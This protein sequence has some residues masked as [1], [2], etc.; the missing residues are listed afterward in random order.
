M[1]F[2]YCAI[3]IRL[4]SLKERKLIKFNNISHILFIFYFYKNKSY[5]LNVVKI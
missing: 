4:V 5:D 3:V 1:I 2:L